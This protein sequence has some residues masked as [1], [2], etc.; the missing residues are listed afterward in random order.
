MPDHAI[1]VPPKNRLA[2]AL[3]AI[4]LGTFGV[5]HFYLDNTGIGLLYLLLFWTGIP[6]FIGFIEGVC[7][8]LMSDE[9]FALKFP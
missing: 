3:L 6:T 1:D 4:S 9:R 8:L 5:H 7:W 2:A